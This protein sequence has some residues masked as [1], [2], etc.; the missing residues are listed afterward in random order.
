[1]E[2]AKIPPSFSSFRPA[3]KKEPS[4]TEQTFKR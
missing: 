1:M 4:D 3:E 2:A